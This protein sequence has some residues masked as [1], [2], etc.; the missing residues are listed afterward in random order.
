MLKKYITAKFIAIFSLI[1]SVASI[2]N[3]VFITTLDFDMMQKKDMLFPLDLDW[4]LSDTVSIRSN[5]HNYITAFFDGLL[6]IGA[7]LF[8]QSKYRHGRL[9]R[10]FFSIVFISNIL[11]FFGS[12]LVFVVNM[13]NVLA[14][15]R[16][17]LDLAYYVI[18]FFWIALSYSVLAYFNTRISLETTVEIYEN[19]PQSFFV[20]SSLSRRFLHPF[21]DTLVSI[22]VFS[23][24]LVFFRPY[25][26]I[27]SIRNMNIFDHLY[28]LLIIIRLV[29]YLLFETL[30]GVTAAKILT[31]SRL[32]NHEGNKPSFKQV[33]IRTISRLVP[34]EGF[35]FFAND[36][37]HDKWS[38][39]MVV[40]EKDDNPIIRSDSVVIED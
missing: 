2:V 31:G 8:I 18:N 12:V 4:F 25:S 19:Q 36:G 15:G 37:W 32:I 39:T 7:L 17:L 13:K 26:P 24:S 40:E 10:F 22:A 1:L 23:P 29:Y 35:S 28:L 21:I 38:A 33:F 14:E 20:N 11:Q 30:L 3:H 6:L 5:G 34:F 27:A 9:I 16:L